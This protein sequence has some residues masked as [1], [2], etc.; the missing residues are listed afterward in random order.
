VGCAFIAGWLGWSTSASW[1]QLDSSPDIRPVSSSW[2]GVQFFSY[3]NAVEESATPMQEPS[4]FHDSA[5]RSYWEWR[6]GLADKHAP[7][8][9][10]AD[11]VHEP[12]EIMLEYKYMIMSM[13]EN[14][15]GTTRLSNDQAF[16]QGQAL[17]TNNGALPTHMSMEMHMVHI[18]YGW[19]ENV[20]LYTMLMFPVLTMDHIRGP[21]NPAGAGT[22]FTTHNSGFGDLA[23]G[24]L[25][26]L[27]N[28]EDW[29]LIFNLGFRVPT[30]DISRQTTIPT[31]GL[32]SQELP[33][34]MRLGTGTFQFLP[35]IT[36]KRYLSGGSYGLQF[37]T[38]FSIGENW[39]HYSVPDVY[40]L[41]FWYAHLLT[42]HLAMSFRVENLWRDNF[43]GADPDLNPAVVSTSRPDMQTGY[44]LN[45]GYGV[46]WLVG[47]S[48]HLVNLE[49]IDT[50]YQDLDGIQLRSDWTFVVSWSKAY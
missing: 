39:D 27:L 50:I 34:P 11:H 18:M 40:R 41:N 20:T 47:D 28:E 30:G 14:Q 22:V 13:D 48:G 26:R 45:F 4:R 5:G 16:A 24:G 10:M 7:A 33:Y 31:G 25:F 32:V 42:D 19:S 3:E 37:Q 44:W 36:Y 49:I 9:L 35:G 43:T 29:D 46:M 6:R 23:F 38:N 15:R 2:V 12:G 8:F 1:A 17:G 21:A